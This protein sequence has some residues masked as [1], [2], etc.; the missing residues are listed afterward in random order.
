M[1]EPILLEIGKRYR[2]CIKK[3]NYF[4]VG[5]NNNPQKRK[6]RCCYLGQY[7]T[8]NYRDI[9]MFFLGTIDKIYVDIRDDLG[10]FNID[11]DDIEFL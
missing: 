4:S 6:V 1:Y 2:F 5:I 9:D 8:N 11:L 10:Y 3:S 7:I